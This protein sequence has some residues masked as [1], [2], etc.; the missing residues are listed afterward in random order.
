[1]RYLLSFLLYI[2][3]LSSIAQNAPT[4]RGLKALV[5]SYF[6]VPEITKYNP[7]TGHYFEL[8]NI[9]ASYM[10]TVGQYLVKSKNGL[11]LLPDGTGRVYEIQLLNS[12]FEIKRQDSTIFFGYNF[13]FYPF[14]YKE[15]LYS[16]GGYGY[17]R[18]NG[19]LRAFLPKKG[20]WQIENLNRE[21]PFGRGVYNIPLVWYNESK[22]M[23]WI[24]FSIYTQ[25]GISKNIRN[26]KNVIDSVYSLDLNK[27]Q[28]S[29]HGLM[30]PKV[31]NL[32]NALSTRNLGS[33]PWGQLLYDPVE[34]SILL[35]NFNENK[36][37][38]LNQHD[39]KSLVDML[40][41]ESI[42]YFKDSTLHVGLMKTWLTN[43]LS[44]TD[45]LRLTKKQFLFLESP[46]YTPAQ[47]ILPIKNNPYSSFQILLIGISIGLSMSGLLALL[48]K[49]KNRIIKDLT[50]PLT[51]S[52]N[53]LTKLFDDKEIELLSL[54][55]TN[56]RNFSGTQ[57]ED[58]NKL[59]GVLQKNTEI[60]KKQRSETFISINR[61][62][63]YANSSNDLLIK[64]K[65]LIADKRSFEYFIELSDLEK[66]NQLGFISIFKPSN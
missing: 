21:I 50:I 12:K 18:Y 48:Y 9:Q 55:A 64:K 60:Q 59:L 33:S 37:Q 4:N 25:E 16:F 38:R 42:I 23:L 41:A 8:D 36:I 34:S 47:L 28:W 19:Q 20:E 57:I 7:S 61:K 44:L 3:I 10:R 58:I 65:R 24:G 11:F 26:S 30:V 43:P 15:T 17:W 54:V 1:M 52:G 49:F 22:G 53:T 5:E 56:S 40:E 66:I 32:V 29:V 2:I 62:W 46:L 35:L 27:K 6:T 14:C 31:K 51:K 13:G 45:S 39:T 63:R